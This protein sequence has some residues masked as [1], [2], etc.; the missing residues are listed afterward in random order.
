MNKKVEDNSFKKINYMLR[1]RKQIERKIIIETL[2]KLTPHINIETYKYI[3]MGATSYYDF[4]LFHKFL[5]IKKLL[6]ID[7]KESEKKFEF[8]KPYDFIEFQHKKSTDFLSEFSWDE[9]VFIWL[10]YDK[11]LKD[12]M[13][14][15]IAIVTKRCHPKD[16]LIFTINATCP[17]YLD[18]RKRFFNKYKRYI[19]PEYRELKFI[20]TKYFDKL[21]YEICLNHI[22]TKEINRDVKFHQ[23]FLFNYKDGAEMLTVGGIFD[24]D[25]EI[26]SN[27]Q[28][29]NYIST[30]KEAVKIEVPVLTYCEKL[31]LDS[32]IGTIKNLI[33]TDDQGS[34]SDE[35][36]N[37]ELLY[38]LFT[39][40]ELRS[41]IQYYKYFPQ[42]YEGII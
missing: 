22:R 32:N 37:E 9:H 40:E 28:N 7:D 14:T 29:L 20:T 25:D 8:N 10:D 39:K 2:Q 41:Y 31:Y 13:L 4:I 26:I 21:L 16:I 30:G 36:I 27:I 42:Y 17:S 12:Y 5:N 34:G 18:D 33:E 38:E 35:G 24:K 1:P 6:S 19:P 15:D 3:G 23:I 11:T